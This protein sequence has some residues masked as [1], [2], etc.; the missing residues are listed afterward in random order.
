MDGAVLFTGKNSAD[1]ETEDVVE[2]VLLSK[3]T[4]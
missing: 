4:R 3:D 1:G 2:T